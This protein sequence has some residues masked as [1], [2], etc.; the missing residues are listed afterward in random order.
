MTT[1]AYSSGDRACL[2]FSSKSIHVLGE[3]SARKMTI[4]QCPSW[5]VKNVE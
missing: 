2:L 1:L 4:D 3:W 5:V